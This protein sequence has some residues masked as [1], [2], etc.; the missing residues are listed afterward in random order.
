MKKP[1]PFLEQIGPETDPPAVVPDP[2]D[3]VPLVQPD[4]CMVSKARHEVAIYQRKI[5]EY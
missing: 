5:Q 4:A 2:P 1:N 3:A